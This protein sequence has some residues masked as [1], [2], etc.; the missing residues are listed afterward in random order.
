MELR[1][2]ILDLRSFAMRF[3]IGCLISVFWHLPVKAER[4]FVSLRQNI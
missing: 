3:I 1:A 4:Q 2:F